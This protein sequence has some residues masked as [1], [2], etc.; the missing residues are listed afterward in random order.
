MGNTFFAFAIKNAVL[1]WLDP[2]PL[3]YSGREVSVAE[4]A[5]KLA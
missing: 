1:D 3:T 4:F 2:K 5:A